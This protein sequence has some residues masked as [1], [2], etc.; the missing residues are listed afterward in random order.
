MLCVLQVQGEHGKGWRKRAG[1]KFSLANYVKRLCAELRPRASSSTISLK[2]PFSET[3]VSPKGDQE[4]KEHALSFDVDVAVQKAEEAVQRWREKQTAFCS[5]A[6]GALPT[7]ASN[8]RTAPAEGT[9][10]VSHSARLLFEL[11]LT[12]VGI[13]I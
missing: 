12:P 8:E 10:A 6:E 7:E 2:L 1:C 4:A 9:P 11:Y 13:F 3:H 5:S